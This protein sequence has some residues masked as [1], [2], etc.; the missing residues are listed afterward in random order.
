MLKLTRLLILIAVAAIVAQPVM[1]CC[2]TGHGEPQITQASADMPL[3]HGEQT[4]PE[5]SEQNSDHERPS[6]ADCPGCIDCDAGVMQAQSFDDG[7]LLVQTSTEF[8]VAILT[9]RFEGFGHKSTVL[10]T[11]PPGD[12]PRIHTTPIT[13]KQRL[14]I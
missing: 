11:G 2:L 9:A 5:H 4:A 8:P 7:T 1:A 13:L 12:P 10:K 6:P 14:L 3:C